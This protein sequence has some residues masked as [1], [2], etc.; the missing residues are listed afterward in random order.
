MAYADASCALGVTWALCEC[1]QM[2]RDPT[3]DSS[4][5]GGQNK[6]RKDPNIM[7]LAKK[8]P[9]IFQ[10]PAQKKWKEVANSD[11]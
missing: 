10:I 7:S 3:V 6:Q 4:S 1:R 5:G 8:T 2:A 9:N 11:R